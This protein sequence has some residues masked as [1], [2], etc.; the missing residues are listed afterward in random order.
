M[1]TNGS[2][3]IYNK[4]TIP[5]T[6]NVIYKGTA[7]DNV[8]WDSVESVTERNGANKQDEVLVYIPFDKNDVSNYVQ[9][10][11]YNGS[12]DKWTLKEGDIII[13]GNYVNDIP[14][15]DK[16]SDLKEYE[17]FTIYFTDTKDFGN[18]NMQHFKVKGK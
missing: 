12:S 6:K 14:T 16:I 4:H 10:K 7:I 13:K 9:P 15:I 5:E 17:V 3:T 11:Q 2:M 18:Y 1:F 8:F